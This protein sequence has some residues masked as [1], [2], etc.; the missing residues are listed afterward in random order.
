MTEAPTPEVAAYFGARDETS[1]VLRTLRIRFTIMAAVTLVIIIT[2][3]IIFFVKVDAK[4]SHID[5]TASKVRTVQ[6]SNSKLSNQRAAC[7]STASDDVVKDLQML[8]LGH[9][10]YIIPK[11]C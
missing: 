2:A 9:H 1:S 10:N 8:A 3:A 7:S 4:V 5:M 11:P 6:K